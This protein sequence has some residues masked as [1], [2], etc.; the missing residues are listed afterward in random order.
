VVL[1]ERR[2][3]APVDPAA[4]A[5]G[6]DLILRGIGE[7]PTRPGLVETPRRVAE[8]LSDLVAGYGVDPVSVLEP[9]A[10][11]RGTGLIM[12]RAIPIASLCEHHLLPFTGTAAVAYLP[13]EDG[14][15]TGLSKLA[16]LMDVLSRRLQ[17]QERLVREAADALE[18]ALAPR[19][20]FVLI[21]AE[22]TCGNHRSARRLRRRRRRARGAGGAR[23]RLMEPRPRIDDLPLANGTVLRLSERTHVMGILNV[24]PDSFSDGGRFFDAEAAL[25]QGIAL[26]ENGADI[27]DI[28]G[29]STRPGAEPVD[30]G[31]EFSRVV[32]VIE[33]LRERIETPISIDT[34]KADVAAAALDAGADIVNDVSAGRFDTEMVGLVASRAVPVVLMHMLGE[35]RTMQEVPA[36]EDVVEDVAAFLASRAATAMEAGVARNKIIVDPGFGFGKT[37][38]HNLELL[39]NLRR[40]T[41]LGYPVLAGTSRK[42]FIGATLD[43][44]VGERLEGTAATVAL[45]VAAGASIVRVHDVGPM[46]RVASMVEAVLRATS[47]GAERER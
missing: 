29:E 35:P 28:G 46:R 13:A 16:R 7:D 26:A 25:K 40:F 6:V 42:S 30:P 47:S 32:P 8:S 27:I 5:R 41:E 10:D 38:E 14:R 43:L 9:L 37:R 33:G 31:E 12:M 39:R 18:E 17:V 15:I 21:E 2:E 44:P 3:R 19:G 34:T 4:I 23:A 45:A 1:G 36:Y 11:E 24:T 22:H 20:V